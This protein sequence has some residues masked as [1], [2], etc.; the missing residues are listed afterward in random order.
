M[1]AFL[2]GMLCELSYRNNLRK[3]NMHTQHYS[4]KH[5]RTVYRNQES[6]V[7]GRV[8]RFIVMVM[9]AIAVVSGGLWLIGATI[10]LVFGL[11][12]LALGLAPVLIVGWLIWVVVKAIFY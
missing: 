7:L 10:G 4:N 12:A 6:S 11:F 3:F 5:R 8:A 2:V 1:R 9:I